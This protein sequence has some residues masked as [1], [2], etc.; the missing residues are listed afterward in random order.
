M[1]LGLIYHQFVHAGGLENYLIEFARRL[2]QQGHEIHIIT[3]RVAPEVRSRLKDAKWHMIERPAVS[4]L[5]RLYLF[6]KAAATMAGAIDVD[7]TV[8][9]GRTTTHDLHRAGGGCHR[10]YSKV[11]PWYKRYSPK[12]L[13]ELLLEQRLYNSG[14]TSHFIMNSA[15]V[16]A[17]IQGIYPGARGKC[18]VIHTA[19]DTQ[20]YRPAEDR[21]GLR[22]EVC[23]E[24]NTDPSR[25]IALFVSLSHRRKGLDA[26]L[27]AWRNVDATLWIVGKPLGGRYMALIKQLGISAKVRALPSTSALVRYY[28]VADWFVHPTLYDACANTVLQSMACGVPGL[29]SA[30]DGAIDHVCEG[31]NGFILYHPQRVDELEKKLNHAFSLSEEDRLAMGEKARLAMLP[32]TWDAHLAQWVEIMQQIPRASLPG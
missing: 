11:L 32:L 1:K 4:A 24:L 27:Q 5:L 18:S 9:F 23:S 21:A 12:N 20:H 31:E 7:L 19:V 2:L 3:S 29:I 26:L 30:L 17:Q 14:H 25:P 8:G 10:L 16:V 28:Q 13:L 15:R 22:A 6:N